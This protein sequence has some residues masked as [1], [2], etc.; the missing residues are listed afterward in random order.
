MKDVAREHRQEREQRHAEKCRRERQDR[1][2]PDRPLIAH[3]LQPG[4][5]LVDA[6][7]AQLALV[8]LLDELAAAPSLAERRDARLELAELAGLA[9]REWHGR[10]ID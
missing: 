1:Q 4:A 3:V 5:Q 2:R 10:G 7:P 9:L 6:V 8:A